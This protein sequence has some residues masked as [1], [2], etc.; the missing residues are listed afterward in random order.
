MLQGNRWVKKRLAPAVA[1]VLAMPL[2]ATAQ[3]TIPGK[4]VLERSSSAGETFGGT[5]GVQNT[6][7]KPQEARI[8]QTDFALNPDGS[9]RFEDPGSSAR[10]NAKWVTVGS[11]IVI[12]PG[13]T[14]DVPYNVVV[15]NVGLSGT[16]WSVVMIEE[17]PAGS[18]ESAR[19][20]PKAGQLQ[21]GFTSQLR[22]AVQI[23]THIGQKTPLK[24]T[25]EAPKAQAVADT[26]FFTFDLRNTGEMGFRPMVTL[27][28]YAE[29][30]SHVKT[31]KATRGLTFPGFTI[32]QRFELGRL[33]R[34]RYRAIV[35]ADLGDG[36][37]IGARYSFGL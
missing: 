21:L 16:Y 1:C 6:T 35:T 25:F 24:A 11:R 36:T 22:A 32:R 13:M 9:V 12:P 20:A 3:F 2:A 8:Y 27:E 31:L 29:D 5:I 7:G 17:V 4:L 19:S 30:G 10:S 15:P 28:L 33:A 23:V 26:G 37:V 14:V 34:G 18:P